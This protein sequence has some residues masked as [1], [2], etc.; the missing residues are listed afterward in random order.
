MARRRG[1][2]ISLQILALDTAT[3]WCS[4]ALWRDGV[5]DARE[6]H[7]GQRHSELILPMIDALLRAAHLPLSGL[8]AIA[9][10]SG[11]GSFTGLRIACGVAQGMAYGAG[12]KLVPVSTLEALAQASGAA[13]VIAALDA[14]MGE[15]YHAA[16]VRDE[17]GW[18]CAAG[19]SLCRP[20]TAPLVAGDDWMGSGSGFAVYGESLAARYAGKLAGTRPDIVPLARHILPGAI[21]AFE[22]GEAVSP[23]LAAPLYVRDKVAMTVAERAARNADAR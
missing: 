10:G 12:L 21:A 1:A 16:Y 20:Q 17:R 15:I 13:R 11:P 22:R 4:A 23:A 2:F 5:V 9:F 8:D 7:A 14:R 19:P 18:Y 6:A 3:E